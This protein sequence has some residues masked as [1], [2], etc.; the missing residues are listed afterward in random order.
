VKTFSDSDTVRCVQLS[1]EERGF[2]LSGNESGEI[3][4]WTINSGKQ[5]AKIEAHDGL[6]RCMR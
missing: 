4:Q 2:V 5:T 6:V 1:A 3:T